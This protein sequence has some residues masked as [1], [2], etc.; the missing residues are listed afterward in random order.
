MQKKEMK[1]DINKEPLRILSMP[2]DQGGCGWYRVRQ[3]FEMLQKFSRAEVHVVDNEKDHPASIYEALKAADV[4]IVRQGGEEGLRLLKRKYPEIKA[5]TVLDIDDNIEIISPYSEHYKDY[6]IAPYFDKNA[7]V[8]LWEDGKN[9]FDLEKNKAKVNSLIQGMKEVDMITCTTFLLKKYAS[10]YN[11]NV[12]VLPNCV[13]LDKWWKPNFKRNDQ[14]RVGWSGGI[15]HYEDFYSIKKSL[16][17]LL[18]E[19]QF[20]LVMVGAHFPGIIDEENGHL[21][22]VHDWVPFKGHSYRMMMMN[23]DVAIIPL[24]DLPFNHYKSSIKWYEMSAMGVPSLVSNIPPYSEDIEDNKTAIGYKTSKQFE[25]G[26]KQLLVKPQV[27]KKIGF[28]ARKWVEKNRDA[29]KC[30]TM[31]IDVYES[32]RRNGESHNNS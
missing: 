23:L 26:L 7:N 27:R 17:K 9:G 1:P 32:F 29:R 13:N 11:S 31:Q 18:K 22:E 30:T 4:L 6:G 28:A 19:Y 25:R 15:S 20:K 16:N 21:V 12:H 2:V 3:P 14:L 24:A 10:Q 5:K 8:Q